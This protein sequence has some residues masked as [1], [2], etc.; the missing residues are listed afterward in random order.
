MGMNEWA[1]VGENCESTENDDVAHTQCS[2]KSTAVET[3]DV[4]M[5][6]VAKLPWTIVFYE[7]HSAVD[8]RWYLRSAGCVVFGEPIAASLATDG[9]HYFNRCWRHAAA[10]VMSPPLRDDPTTPAYLIDLLASCALSFFHFTRDV[11]LA[12]YTWCHLICRVRRKNET[13]QTHDRNSVKS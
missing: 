1:V 4:A 3:K 9:S 7:L 10:F 12:Q 6:S 11:T 13:P 5:W 2:K 8:S